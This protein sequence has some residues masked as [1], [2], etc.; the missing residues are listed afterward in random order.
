[1][2]DIGMADE[3]DQ[4][5]A[6]TPAAERWEILKTLAPLYSDRMKDPDLQRAR[7]ARDGLFSVRQY[8]P[9]EE[10]A[11]IDAALIPSI[12]R[13]VREGRLSGGRHSLDKMVEAIGPPAAAPLLAV[14][15]DPRAPFGGA[16]E[17]LGK[18]ADDATRDRAAAA[19]VQRAVALHEVP[20]ALWRAL[21]AMGGRAA[22]NFLMQK[23]E[24]GNE[25]AA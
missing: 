20:V 3:V 10:R 25:S 6:R 18:V 21:G 1:M 8:A 23:A 15:E 13:D 19:L 14:L 17:L 2:V 9:A 24:K 12:A 16:A 5:L 4:I 7:A 22:T 11:Q